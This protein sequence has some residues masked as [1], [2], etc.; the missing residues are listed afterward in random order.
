M[1][2]PDPKLQAEIDAR[3]KEAAKKVH[4][5][6]VAGKEMKEAIHDR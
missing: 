1:A 4:E 2:R 3:A 6:V 5:D